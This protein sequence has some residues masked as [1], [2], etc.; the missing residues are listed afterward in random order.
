MFLI[1]LILCQWN[2]YSL[3][4]YLGFWIMPSGVP[5]VLGKSLSPS[6]GASCVGG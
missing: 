3:E 4:G 2:S 6:S 5:D 1:D